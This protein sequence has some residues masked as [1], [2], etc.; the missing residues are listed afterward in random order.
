MPLLFSFMYWV[1]PILFIMYHH[2][3]DEW[4]GTLQAHQTEQMVS[5]K[6]LEKARDTLRNEMNKSG[7]K[8]GAVLIR[9]GKYELSSPLEFDETDS[10][11]SEFLLYGKITKVKL[12]ISSVE[13]EIKN[14]EVYQGGIYKQVGTV[15]S[16]HEIFMFNNKDSNSGSLA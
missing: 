13:R 8:G 1:I 3:N 10:G 14:F 7:K 9:K 2:R 5:F 16:E 12:Y 6:T 4:S 15:P 11:S